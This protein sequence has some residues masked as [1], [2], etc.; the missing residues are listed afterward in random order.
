V[1]GVAPSRQV[2][3]TMAKNAC[4]FVR[5]RSTMFAPS[6]GL[7]DAGLT[8]FNDFSAVIWNDLAENELAVRAPSMSP[9]IG[10]SNGQVPPV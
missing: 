4:T 9:A 7:Y 8:L 3:V 5:P 2:Y 10:E 6:I 1:N